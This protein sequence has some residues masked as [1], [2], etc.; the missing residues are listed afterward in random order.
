MYNYINVAY[1][2]IVPPVNSRVRH[3][4]TAKLGRVAPE[5]MAYG[6]YVS[7]RFDGLDHDLPCHPLELDYN[8]EEETTCSPTS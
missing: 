1:G 2:V 8:P 5:N 4:V 7:V 3:T 6:H